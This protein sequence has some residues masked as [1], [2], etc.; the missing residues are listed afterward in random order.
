MANEE[1]LRILRQGVDTWNKWR[2]EH[3]DIRP[4]LT[5]A[6]LSAAN[7]K[8]ANL[9]GADFR[10]A[11]LREAL[12]RLADLRGADLGGAD[13]IRADLRG[14]DLFRADLRLAD[15]RLADLSAA[16]LMR[17]NLSDANL[18][19]ANLSDAGLIEA[20]LS[21][22]NLTRVNLTGASLTR[23]NLTGANLTGAN[24][25]GADIAGA[26]LESALLLDTVL[27]R[28]D[29][30]A[31]RVYGV[32][33]WGLQI[34][35]AKQTNLAITPEGEP[36]I[37]VDNLEVAQFIYLLL[38]N[39]KIREVIDTI[40]S[41]VV[42]ILGRFTPERK[43]ILDALRDTLRQHNYLPVV[44][45]F[46]KPAS[47][48]LTETVRT[49]AHLARFIIADITDPRSIPQELQAIVPDLAVPV[50]PIIARPQQPWGMFVDF[51]KKYH[52]VLEAH[53]YTDLS[54]LLGDLQTNVIAPAE[55]KA[56]Q[57]AAR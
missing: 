2:E 31:C 7:L 56:K 14:A 36:A 46:D 30:T 49:L 50:Q 23:V 41:K 5:G 22:A 16:V 32:S 38:N 53:E 24:L 35:G 15:L 43:A 28:A 47:R 6:D 26:C 34:E 45:D 11:N 57:L 39:K 40:T 42:L 10:T 37:T 12:L 27:D 1:H 8:E 44:F 48:D 51:P 33:A 29:L 17:A 9:I 13:L 55:A 18:S 25:S 3:P 54:D 4:D 52:W 19:D 20:S 21:G